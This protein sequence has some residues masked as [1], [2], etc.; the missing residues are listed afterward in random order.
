MNTFLSCTSAFTSALAAFKRQDHTCTPARQPLAQHVGADNETRQ[1]AFWQHR[2]MVLK[3]QTVL[4]LELG[5]LRRLLFVEQLRDQ[6]MRIIIRER[7]AELELFHQ[8]EEEAAHLGRDTRAASRMPGEL[9]QPNL[10]LV[11]PPV[12]LN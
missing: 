12:A 7:E 6:V 2:V 8:I 11:L 1:Q 4:R 5:R 9:T 10:T 3:I